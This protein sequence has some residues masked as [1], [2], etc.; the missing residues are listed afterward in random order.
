VSQKRSARL[1][2]AKENPDS[3]VIVEFQS[4][5]KSDTENRA[6]LLPELTADPVGWWAG[7]GG[8][9]YEKLK[10]IAEKILSIICN[11]ASSERIWSKFS[12]IHSK[13]RNK[14]KSKTTIVLCI[15]YAWLRMK[16]SQSQR[17]PRL[18]ADFVLSA[19]EANNPHQDLAVIAN[20][21][22]IVADTGFE[23]V[24]DIVEEVESQSLQEIE[25]S[26]QSLTDT[27][28]IPSE[29]M[30]EFEKT[31]DS[32]VDSMDIENLDN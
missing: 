16:H 1:L 25:I 13:I 11:S 23:D 28:G 22:E 21:E 9:Y 31:V 18:K 10:P 29:T 30:D 6:L 4:F 14:L 12:L 19:F 27:L 32:L 26:V 7:T 17:R 24:E 2:L 8:L 20:I 15:I 5:M 3:A